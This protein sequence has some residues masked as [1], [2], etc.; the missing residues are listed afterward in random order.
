MKKN[1]MHKIPTPKESNVYSKRM[2]RLSYDSFGVEHGYEHH[3]F[4]KHAIPSGLD[5]ILTPKESNV[6]S[7][8]MVRPSYDSFGVEHGYE[9]HHFYKHAI[10]SGLFA[11]SQSFS[12]EEDREYKPRRG[13]TL[14]TAGFN[15]LTM[16]P[17]PYP[18]PAGTT[19]FT[20]S[21]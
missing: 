6:Y 20:T 8:R 17:I 2:V 18:S 19:L 14:L 13:D 5:D 1:I 3:H 21:K 9:H 7:K 11:K 15:L 16:N 10:P 4:Y 12:N